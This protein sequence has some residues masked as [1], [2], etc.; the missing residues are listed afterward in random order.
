MAS[1]IG[2]DQDSASDVSE[3]EDVLE[4]ARTNGIARDHTL[5]DTSIDHLLLMQNELTDF[6]DHAHLHQP[7]APHNIEEERMSISQSAARLLASTVQRETDESINES[8]LPALDCRDVREMHVELPLLRTDHQSDCRDFASWDGFE[9]PLQNINFPLEMVDIENNEGLEFPEEFYN[10][11][12]ETMEKVKQEKIEVMKSSIFFLQKTLKVDFSTQEKD[13]VWSSALTPYKRQESSYVTPPLSPMV[14]SPVTSP[15]PNNLEIPDDICQIPLLSDPVSL[16]GGD[17][18][19]IEDRLFKE[20]V[21]TPIRDKIYGQGEESEKQYVN[22]SDIYSPPECL[23]K[24]ETPSP[25]ERQNIQESKIEETLTPPSPTDLSKKVRFNKVIEELLYSRPQSVLPLSDSVIDSKFF[26]EAFGKS[27]EQA[28]QQVEQ[29]KLVDTTHRVDVPTMDFSTPRPPWLQADHG[30]DAVQQSI[31]AVITKVKLELIWPGLKQLHPKLPW[32]PF[33][34]GL[35]KV[36]LEEDVCAPTQSWELFV[37]GPD[38][39][40]VVTSSDL[41]WK[42][43]GL[44][45]L[46]ED[47]DDEEEELEMGHFETDVQDISSLIRKRKKEIEVEQEDCEHVQKQCN[48]SFNQ[49]AH[50]GRKPVQELNAAGVISNKAPP[51]LEKRNLKRT[52]AEQQVQEPFLTDIFSSTHSLDKFLEI[53]GVKRPKLDEQPEPPVPINHNS[54]QLPIRASP[55]L[56]IVTPT[57][58][59]LPA[60]VIPASDLPVDIILSSTMLKN[61]PLIRNLTDLIPKLNIIERDFSAHNTVTWLPNSITRSPNTSPLAW[62]ADFIISPSTGIILTTLQKIKQKPLPGQKT[63]VAIRDRIEKVSVRYE[64][65]TILVM[66]DHTELDN[67]DCLAW[68]DFVGWTL[69]LDGSVIVNLVPEEEKESLSRWIVGLM[70]KYRV[71]SERRVFLLETETWWEIFL[72]KAGMNAYAAQSVIGDLRPPDG[73]PEGE[74]M[75]GKY[76]LAA[77]VRM[78]Q[79][80]RT[81]RFGRMCGKR[82]IDRVGAAIETTW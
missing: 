64:N 82:V 66:S 59:P 39:D 72:R 42:L 49:G 2:M 69:S 47:S 63:N 7:Q 18:E 31:Q 71:P 12:V 55:D 23:G 8:I 25:Q 78:S 68:A 44:K 30:I 32:A 51:T 37:H 56:P 21:P 52:R 14:L 4:Y 16:T 48:I 26:E 74:A 53:R 50:I 1:N 17:L 57:T 36:A 28:M 33:P 61:R 13:E 20:D 67:N 41:T 15:L 27:G 45:I 79:R 35:A 9:I 46:R 80:E 73:V 5:D 6:L 43:E 29:E 81:Q 38:D 70:I 54:I 34:H 65:L 40:D 19:K 62:E 58:Q 10:F 22:P 11:E 76:G 24:L 75:D 60:P 3:E 77:F